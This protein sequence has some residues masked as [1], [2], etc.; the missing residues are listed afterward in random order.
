MTTQKH[1]PTPYKLDHYCKTS[2]T[3]TSEEGTIASCS[4][5]TIGFKDESINEANAAFI[6]R[7]C[8]AHEE[9]VQVLEDLLK[10]EDV[11]FNDTNIHPSSIN[12]RAIRALAKA[13]GEV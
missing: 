7:A 3:D 5:P 10:A 13:K 9:L 12:G 11:D 4:S 8:N 1:T 2:I 6:V